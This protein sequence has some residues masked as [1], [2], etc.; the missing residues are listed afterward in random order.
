MA[1]RPVFIAS[2]DKNNYVMEKDINFEWFPGFSVSQKQKSID[3]FH[4]NVRKYDDSLRLLEVSSK[5]KDELGVALSAFNLKITTKSGKEFS[6]E[7]AFQASK[8]FQNGGPF[9]DLY[10]KTSKDAKKDMRIKN[11]GDLI[12]FQFFNRRW[13]LEPKTLFY[14]WLYINALALNKRLA[15]KVVEYNAFTDIEFNPQKSIN[16]QAKSVALY[17]SL[18]KANLLDEALESVDKYKQI[19]TQPLNKSPNENEKVTKERIEQ[20]SIFDEIE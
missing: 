7:T 13:E 3:S 17:V 1:K 14:D 15:E 10:E 5:S 4:D 20:L 16:C 12:Y 6:V 8:V 9:L 11:S 18:Y 19:I 2:K